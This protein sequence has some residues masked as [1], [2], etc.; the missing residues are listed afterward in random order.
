MTV[1][2]CLEL[3][4]SLCPS[5]VAR[6]VK[7]QFLGEIEGRVRVELLEEE[8]GEGMALPTELADD[9]VLC[10][11]APYDRLYWLYLAAMLYFVSGY[12]E[13]YEACAALFN[14]AYRDYGK[15]LRRK[16]V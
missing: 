4:D 15:W 14:A 1:K 5:S 10:V 12:M 13:K 11:P 6:E 2:N 7:L 3:V 8:L 9:T 16:G